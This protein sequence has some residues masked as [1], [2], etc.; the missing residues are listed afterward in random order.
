MLKEF[1]DYYFWVSPP[2][3]NLSSTDMFFMWLFLAIAA[4]GI[5]A[6]ILSYLNYDTVRDTAIRKFKNL[7]L[8]TGLSGL[9]WFGIRYENTPI[10][11]N[12]YW[13]GGILLLGLIWLGF[14]LKYM[15]FDYKKTKVQYEREILK[16]RYLPK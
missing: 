5:A 4:L 11:S 9:I 2:S 6:I 14:F 13:A 3:I 12:R 1:T 16:Q 8:T 7:T 15:I 10:F